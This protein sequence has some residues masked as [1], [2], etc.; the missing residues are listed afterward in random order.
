MSDRQ[1]DYAIGDVTHLCLVYERLVAELE[2]QGRTS[3]VEEDMRA[4]LNPARY[5][6]DPETAY[7]KIKIRRPTAQQLAVLRGLAAWRERE[8]VD[9]DVPRGWVVRDEALAEIA[10]HFP[11]DAKA[12]SRVRGFKEQVAHGSV[13]RAILDEM[14]KALALPKEQWPVV[15]ERG[16]APGPGHEALVA[17][18]QALLRLRADANG[19]ATTMLANRADFERIATYEGA[20]DPDVEDPDIEALRGWRREIFGQAAI[21]LKAGRLG[22][23]GTGDGVREIVPAP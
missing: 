5:V 21:D 23:A 8:A 16:P 13:G 3:W 18:L 4:L 11:S 6:T 20:D 19:V 7:R 9:R 12:L 22:L 17:L 1:L 15:K 14:A 2:E 10:Q